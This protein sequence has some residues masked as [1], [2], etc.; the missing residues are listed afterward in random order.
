MERLL[1][2]S[3][4]AIRIHNTIYL[5]LPREWSALYR[6][7]RKSELTITLGGDGTLIIKAGKA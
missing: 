2:W 7:N 4:K 5:A 6:V 1:K 3:R